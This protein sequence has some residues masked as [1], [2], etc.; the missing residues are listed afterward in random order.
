[1]RFRRN[2]VGVIAAMR[3]RS[4]LPYRRRYGLCAWSGFYFPSDPNATNL[5]LKLKPPNP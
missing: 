3:R 5:A 4:L 1:M 2:T